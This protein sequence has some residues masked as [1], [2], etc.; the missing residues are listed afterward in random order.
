MHSA[1]SSTVENFCWLNLT[2]NNDNVS[3]RWLASWKLCERRVKISLGK[4]N[5]IKEKLNGKIFKVKGAWVGLEPN[6]LV[7]I[8]SFFWV[9]V[10]CTMLTYIGESFSF[11]SFVL[12]MF[13]SSQVYFG[14]RQIDLTGFEPKCPVLM[15]KLADRSKCHV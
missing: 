15:L 4:Y 5:K 11:Q 14:D 8:F 7:L 10:H 13:K 2:F 6:P 9:I 12:S 3:F 1:I